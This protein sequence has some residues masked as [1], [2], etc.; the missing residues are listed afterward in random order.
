[1]WQGNQTLISYKNRQNTPI[2]SSG[3]PDN[4]VDT[5]WNFAFLHV[6]GFESIF[7]AQL[8]RALEAARSNIWPLFAFGAGLY[9]P[10]SSEDGVRYRWIGE[11]ELPTGR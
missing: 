9:H 3:F 10:I 8:F 4:I 5:N 1:M 2:S 11:G 6:K 7:M